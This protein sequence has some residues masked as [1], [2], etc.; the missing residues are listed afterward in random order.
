MFA[1]VPIYWENLTK[2]LQ[3]REIS[4][5]GNHHFYASLARLEYE[6]SPTYTTRMW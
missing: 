4:L 5:L 2:T 6:E 3:Y 1:S